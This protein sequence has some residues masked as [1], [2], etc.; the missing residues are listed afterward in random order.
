M[1][2]SLGFAKRG[3]IAWKFVVVYDRKYYIFHFFLFAPGAGSK[4][5]V[6]ERK[7]VQLAGKK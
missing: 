7:R 4:K 2:Q 3:G 1:G 5:V 6:G